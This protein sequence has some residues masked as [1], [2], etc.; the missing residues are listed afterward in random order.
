MS[1]FEDVGRK[2]DDEMQKLRAYWKEKVGPNTERQAAAALR[3]VSQRLAR[4]AE[5]LEARI[6]ANEKSKTGT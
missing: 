6:A 4:A 5:E 1:T 2:I 3:K